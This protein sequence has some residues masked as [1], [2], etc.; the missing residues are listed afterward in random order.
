MKRLYNKRKLYLNNLLN[1]IIL[2]IV[3]VTLV[4]SILL[5]RQK[6]LQ[7]TQELGMRSGRAHV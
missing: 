5:V 4:L 2:V 3:L 7:N 1:I 6:L